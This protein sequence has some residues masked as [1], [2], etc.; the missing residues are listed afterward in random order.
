M[1]QLYEKIVVINRS[2]ISQSKMPEFKQVH[3]ATRTAHLPKNL[4]FICAFVWALSVFCTFNGS[5]VIT[6]WTVFFFSSSWAISPAHLQETRFLWFVARSS[7]QGSRL[8][9]CW[10]RRDPSSFPWAPVGRFPASAFPRSLAPPYGVNLWSSDEVSVPPQALPPH[11]HHCPNIHFTPVPTVH[12]HPHV[13]ILSPV[14]CSCRFC[15][16]PRTQHS[17]PSRRKEGSLR[18]HRACLLVS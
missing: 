13:N 3:G 4:E 12:P 8:S 7:Y 2:T 18:L 10:L 9:R 5:K 11:L 14:A 17:L 1:Q 15:Y 16:L 6:S